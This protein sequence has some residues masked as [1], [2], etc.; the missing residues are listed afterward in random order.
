[1]TALINAMQSADNTSYSSQ[2]S[3]LRRCCRPLKHSSLFLSTAA[4]SHPRFESPQPTVLVP[5]TQPDD[6]SGS[7]QPLTKIQ[8]LKKQL[9]DEERR[10][11]EAEANKVPDDL[12]KII[13]LAEAG[14]YGGALD[15]MI[16]KMMEQAKTIQMLCKWIEKNDPLLR[17]TAGDVINMK[18]ELRSEFN[19]HTRTWVK[20][21]LKYCEVTSG[22]VLGVMIHNFNN[23]RLENPPY[24][25]RG[26]AANST[27]E[28][29]PFFK[30]PPTD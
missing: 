19:E 15:R 8:L 5:A 28:Q 27:N 29:D 20:K 24:R 23:K 10:E 21:G 14:D 16:P 25:P 6:A 17:S 13:A 11:R 7:Q 12:A 3:F 30:K 9:A 18:E 4:Q 2:T 26:Q 1:M 22:R